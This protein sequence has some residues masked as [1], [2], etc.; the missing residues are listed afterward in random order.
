MMFTAGYL[1][2][3][4]YRGVPIRWHWSLPLAIVL[5]GGGFG[6]TDAGPSPLRWV[7]VL[8]LVLLHEAGHRAMI[9]HYRLTP[10]GVDMQGLGA[11][12][13]WTGDATPRQEIAIAW[14]GIL[15][16]LVALAVVSL[17]FVIYEAAGGLVTEPW[18]VDVEFVYRDVNAVMIMI[19][20]LP[21][22]TFD[23]DVAWK[24]FALWRGDLQPR[25]MIVI[26]LASDDERSVDAERADR[27]R[28]EV[29]AEVQAITQAHNQRAE[30]ESP[31]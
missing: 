26:Q 8:A 16:Q 22:P 1:E 19:N 9:R 3:G 17:G 29:D 20:L 23:G 12:T 7:L 10:I 18:M 24:V 2:L 30:A 15:A 6:L 27:V 14:G 5:F 25:R 21:L 11:E 31:K 4:R 13:R 28:A